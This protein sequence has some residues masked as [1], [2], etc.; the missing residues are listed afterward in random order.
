MV[1]RDFLLL[2]GVDLDE[3]SLQAAQNRIDSFGARLGRLGTRLSIA[4]SAPIAAATTYALK[5]ASDIEQAHVAFEV[6]LGDANQAKKVMKDLIDFAVNTPFTL[7]GVI[8]TSNMLM[9]MG[10]S[11]NTLIKTLQVLGD[12]SRGRQDLLSRVALAYGQI[13]TAG[14]LRGQELRQLTEAGV[15]I[16]PELS[17][18]TGIPKEDL[19][20]RVSDYNISADVVRQ[21][22]INV[23]S[24]GGRYFKLMEKMMQTIG[25]VF[26]NL[27]DSLYV[28]SSSFGSQIV[29]VLNLGEAIKKFIAFLNK[30]NEQ[31]LDLDDSQKK[32]ILGVT[33]LL[34]VLGP[35]MVFLSTWIKLGTFVISTIR[36]MSASILGLQ[37]GLGSLLV[38][39]L[40]IP[41][42]IMAAMAS[43]FLLIDELN[44]WMKGGDTYLGDFLGPFSKYE[45]RVNSF[46]NKIKSFY[47]NFKKDLKILKGYIETDFITP[48]KDM[49][50]NLFNYVHGL[51]EHDIEKISK[52]L[53]NM[54]PIIW[55]LFSSIVNGLVYA[56][57]TLW[58]TLVNVIYE[59][60]KGLS[61]IIFNAIADSIASA[62]F[63]IWKLFNKQDK[64]TGV[65]KKANKGDYG[66]EFKKA[67]EEAKK[68]YE[69]VQNHLKR[70]GI[71]AFDIASAIDFL[72]GDFKMTPKGIVYT[73][74]NFAFKNKAVNDSAGVQINND[75]KVT[76][77]PGTQQEQVKF[78]EEATDKI[79]KKAL[80]AEW[81]KILSGNEAYSE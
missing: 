27:I 18:L 46:Y 1:L 3:S 15:V 40:L 52:S 80:D 16:L 6:F 73:P 25:G 9:A 69:E 72:A 31:F 7:K 63:S 77:P 62:G 19:A 75:I 37:A 21:A 61:N 4:I 66:Y 38:R 39:V 35:L 49:F 22:L 12:V 26:S 51:V 2:I 79:V 43:I 74:A 58:D 10:E 81:K 50:T 17:R 5:A 48:I 57:M 29:K 44:V 70:G 13:M 60:I 24:E 23:T 36:L 54:G 42:A 30:L 78:I 68:A 65:Y 64:D 59:G 67:Q 47:E 55:K 56:I 28:L 45:E 14:K 53:D 71:T 41:G 32:L 33:A 34:L 8:A 76:V 20:S 11:G